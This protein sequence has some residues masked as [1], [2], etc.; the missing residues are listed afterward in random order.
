LP[1]QE[2]SA[3]AE[4][5]SAT[6]RDEGPYAARLA[7]LRAQR[8]AIE[9]RSGRI[10]SLRGLTFL[11]AAGLA[12]AR[13]FGPVP[14]AVWVGSAGFAVVFI[15]LVVAHAVLVT[16]GVAIELRVGLLE[17]GVRRIAGDFA[18]FPEKGER[19][20]VAGHPYAR[21]LDVFGGSS[22]FQLLGAAETGP[23]EGV[24]AQWLSAP[25][26]A[27]EIA[28]R[29]E[30]VRELAAMPRFREDL[31][32]HGV[33][34]GTRGRGAEPF[35][36]WAE[37]GAL[38]GSQRTLL[39]VGR[40]LVVVTLG[41]LSATK[42]LGLQG[43]VASLW[44]IPLVAQLAVLYRLRPAL[45]PVL[46][47]ATSRE[48]P[49]GRYVA[50]FRLIEGTTFKAPRLTRL[51]GAI[52][53]AAGELGR[54]QT[55]LGYAELRASGLVAVFANAFLLWDAFCAAALLAWRARAGGSVRRWIEAMA[56]LD[57][58][59]AL[60]TFAAEHPSYA[61]PE[62]GTGELCFVAEGLGH[63]LVAPSK[64]VD[65]DVALE[66][67]GSALLVTGSNMSG[68][69]T[70]LRAMGVNAVLAFAG[71]PVCARKLSIAACA[72]HTSMRIDDSLEEGVSHFYAELARLKAVVDAANRGERVLFLLDEVLHGTN[73]RE[74]NI[75][76]KA[77]VRHLL[78]K[79][80]IGAVSSHD[81]GLASLEE[82]SGGGV[83]NVHFQELVD[84]E[85]M[86][87]DYKLKPGVVT[88]SNALR[89]MKV[90]G[91]GVELPE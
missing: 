70:L 74:R 46:A 68:K 40:G 28:E 2:R 23:G 43:W 37:A 6:A 81:L 4:G 32:M 3:P 60:A 42:A 51:R 65:N 5:R 52:A 16:R 13:A 34:S 82:E 53:G 57:A 26:D 14:V 41:L 48:A 30:A 72:V 35:L 85:R 55:L 8:E 45:E 12:G 9:A 86:T 33:E 62:V 27:A 20:L 54:L 63:P 75:G 1:A 89:L 79:G 87:F 25:A 80:E 78:A 64:R 47:P 58:L 76:A 19:F 61:F 90:I 71:A 49:F 39:D 88:S 31:A 10:S 44:V 17:R 18:S 84:G 67:G 83:R 59:A 56:E 73:S 36:R 77:V 11:A 50:L 15:G 66:R 7:E 38:V 24:L 91:I 69:S 29:H 21:D 22:M